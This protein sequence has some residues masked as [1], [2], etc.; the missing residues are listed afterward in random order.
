[1][2]VYFDPKEH[3]ISSLVKDS[4]LFSA[5][6]IICEGLENLAKNVA[7]FFFYGRLSGDEAK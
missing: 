1:M 5:F 7:T 4:T 3:A 6:E 2:Q